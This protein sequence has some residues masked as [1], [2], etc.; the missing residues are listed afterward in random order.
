MRADNRSMWDAKIT[1]RQEKAEVGGS[2]QNG[3]GQQGHVD[4]E[5]RPVLGTSEQH[6]GGAEYK[7][8]T[9]MADRVSKEVTATTASIMVAHTG[10]RRQY[11]LLER[12][13]C[14]LF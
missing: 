2:N 10:L 5:N 12:A 6:Y 13:F 14:A 11:A 7:N 3:S 9:R 1:A 4:A 8:E